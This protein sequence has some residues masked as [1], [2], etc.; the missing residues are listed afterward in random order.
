MWLALDIESFAVEQVGKAGR[1]VGV[2]V[3]RSAVALA[4]ANLDALTNA[5]QDF[6]AGAAS[7]RFALHNVFMPSAKHQV[8]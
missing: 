6:A 7:T 2:D 4:R 8:R 5:S 1:A 3:R